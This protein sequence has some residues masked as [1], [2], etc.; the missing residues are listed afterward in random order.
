MQSTKNTREGFSHEFNKHTTMPDMTIEQKAEQLR[1][2]AEQA[3]AE[4]KAAKE[5]AEAVKADLAEKEAELKTAKTNIDNLD[6]SV[7]ELSAT[8]EALKSMSAEQ[9]QTFNQKMDAFF[10]EHKKEMQEKMA[11]NGGRFKLELKQIYDITTALVNPNYSLSLQSDNEIS[12]EKRKP[13]TF[14]T[15][16]GLAERTAD[17]LEWVEG[18]YQDDVDYVDENGSNSHQSDASMGEVQRQYGKLQTKLIIST[19]ANDWYGMFVDWAKTEAQAALMKKLNEEIWKGEGADTSSSTKK[20]IY[21]IKGHSTAWAVIGQVAKANYADVIFNA[22][23]QISN[24]GYA[25]AVAVV[26]PAVYFGLRNLKDD[27]GNYILDRKTDILCSDNREV[28]IVKGHELT[29][30]EIEVLDLSCVKPYAGNSFEVEGVRDPDYDRFKFFFRRCAQNKI[31]TDWKK[32][33]VYVADADTAV[34]ALLVGPG[35][36]SGS[37]NAAGA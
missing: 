36:G 26:S 4:A 20:K 10:A 37:S 28:R 3:Q 9:R 21:G 17:K 6:S 27:N 18:S 5:A 35:S 19:E 8:V 24:A 33:L 22:C 30:K 15:L 31:K 11:Q 34:A 23:E 32:G 14:I 7:K 25:A 29:G 1:L 16:L 12:A 13:L 2:Q